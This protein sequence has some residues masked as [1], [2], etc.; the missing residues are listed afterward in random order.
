MVAPAAA[1]APWLAAAVRRAA[2]R[3]KP[4]A[5][6]VR[7]A[8]SAGQAGGV[9]GQAGGASGGGGTAGAGGGGGGAGSGGSAGGG[10]S[11]RGGS[12]G[13]SGSGGGASGR[14]G[15][16][17]AV[18]QRR[19]HRWRSQRLRDARRVVVRLTRFARVWP[20]PAGQRRLALP[21]AHHLYQ[22]DDVQLA[23]FGLHRNGVLRLQRQ[24]NHRADADPRHP[25]RDPGLLHSGASPGTASSTLAPP[26]RRDGYRY[27]IPLFQH[28]FDRS[29][30]M[31][32]GVKH[33]LLSVWAVAAGLAAAGTARAD[34]PMPPFPQ[35]A[36]GAP[37]VVAPL[38]TPA[39]VL[40]AADAAVDASN[41]EAARPLYEQLVREHPSS[42]EAGE[43]RRALKNHRR[44]AIGPRRRQ[45]P[46]ARR[47]PM[48]V[49]ASSY[50]GRR[51]R[52]APPNACGCRPGRSW[53]SGRRRSCTG[54]RSA[55][56][57]RSAPATPRTTCC[58]R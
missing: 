45:R 22:R 20:R 43:A 50:A 34:E 57:M 12:G 38:A 1:A 49:T 32:H 16:G 30:A 53:T 48:A 31:R 55:F 2:S 46:T 52:R 40:A 25:H 51:I 11:G 44:R 3:V 6:R 27:P 29:D 19:L 9:A 56:H 18:R 39:D 14:G 24:H 37:V 8:A 41:L 36:P 26:A 10:A 47:E 7:P 13:A 15:S 17:G 54:R 21:L 42:P 58:R 35:S 33:R 23:S 5:S 28:I 4:A